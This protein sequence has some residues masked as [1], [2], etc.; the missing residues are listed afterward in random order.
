MYERRLKIF[1]SI[2]FVVTTVIAL[3][4]GQITIVQHDR[5]SEAAREAMK[6]ES[7]VETTRGRILDYRGEE[8]AVDLP[9]MD[10][11]VDYR[12][13]PP[14]PDETWVR[15]RARRRLN[16]REGKAYAE[17]DRAT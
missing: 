6:R 8:L 9:C 3:R 1:L 16:Q 5:W 14:E 4:A 11:A 2:L 10:I 17:A 12:V 13:I 15:Y 7:Y